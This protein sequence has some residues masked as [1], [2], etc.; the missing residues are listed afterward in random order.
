MIVFLELN[1]AT[2][3]VNDDDAVDRADSR[4]VLVA[5]SPK[6]RKVVDEVMPAFNRHE[7]LVT[8]ALTEDEQI[9]L[10]HAQRAILRTVEA[11]DL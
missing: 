5:L 1:G 9:D 8:Q 11:I 10:A 7:G 2:L 6:S 3:Q 4:R